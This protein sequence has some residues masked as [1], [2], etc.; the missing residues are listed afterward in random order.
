MKSNR[1]VTSL[2]VSIATLRNAGVVRRDEEERLRKLL[3]S[4]SHSIHTK[5]VKG[6]GAIVDKIA[7]IISSILNEE[8]A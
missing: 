4:L 2:S 7:H 1:F 3:K 5:D 8:R 6:I